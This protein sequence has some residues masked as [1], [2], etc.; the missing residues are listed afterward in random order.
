MATFN[1]TIVELKP[2][3][4]RPR[5]RRERPFIVN[6]R[7]NETLQIGR[8]CFKLRRFNLPRHLCGAVKNRTYRGR[9]CSFIFRIHHNRTIVE[10]KLLLA[11]GGRF[12]SAF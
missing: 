3:V 11:Q 9:K 10:L 5:P 6:F 4:L 12:A 8:C 2:E 7:I 1:R